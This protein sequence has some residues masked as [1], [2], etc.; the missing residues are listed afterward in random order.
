MHYVNGKYPIIEW[1]WSHPLFIYIF[2]KFLIMA[3]NFD[4]NYFLLYI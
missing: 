3:D 2:D 1:T 4:K